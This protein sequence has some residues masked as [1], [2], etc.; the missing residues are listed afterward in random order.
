MASLVILASEVGLAVFPV[1]LRVDLVLFVPLAV[2][3]V[4]LTVAAGMNAWS[5]SRLRLALVALVALTWIG[6]LLHLPE[7]RRKAVVNS[8]VRAVPPVGSA[9]QAT[10]KAEPVELR[11]KVR[12]CNATVEGRSGSIRE[13]RFTCD[14]L[15][16]SDDLVLTTGDLKW[17]WRPTSD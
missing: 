13:V 6:S 8:A 9:H 1:S 2:I 10:A 14:L 12:G 5:G 7:L 17:R 15:F 11:G 4:T 16:A 3:G